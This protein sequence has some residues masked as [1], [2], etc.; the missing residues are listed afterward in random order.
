MELGIPGPRRDFA[1]TLGTGDPKCPC[2]GEDLLT[3][4]AE[5]FEHSLGNARNLERAMLATHVELVA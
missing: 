1:H 5:G 2:L 3:T 4:L